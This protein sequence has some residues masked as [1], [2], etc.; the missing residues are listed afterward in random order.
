MQAS[1]EASFSAAGSFG[2]APFVKLTK[3]EILL[4]T[5]LTDKNDNN[6]VFLSKDGQKGAL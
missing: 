4:D 6:S 5:D 1:T 3:T 2:N